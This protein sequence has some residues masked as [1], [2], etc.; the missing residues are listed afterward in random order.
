MDRFIAMR[1]LFGHFLL[2]VSGS[3][4]SQNWEWAA[5]AGGFASDKSTDMGI[6]PA[7]NVYVCGY[8]NGQANFGTISS[9]SGFGKQGFLARIDSQG[10]WQWMREADGGWDERVLGMCVDSVNGFIYVTGC[11]WTWGPG[12]QLS[13]GSYTSFNNPGDADEIFVGKFDYSGNCLWLIGAGGASDDHG[14]DLATDQSGNIYLTGFVS[15]EYYPNPEVA[16]FGSLSSTPMNMGDS[17]GFVAKI[18]PA[19]VFQWVRTFEAV[20]GERDNRIAVDLAGNS[21]ITGGFWGNK[22]F[23]S[24]TVASN[25]GTDIFVV[26]Y[27]ASGTMQWLRTVGSTYDERGNGITI[28]PYGDIYVTGEFR[29]RLVFGTDSLNNNGGPGGRDIFVAKI[30]AA[31]NWIWAKKAGSDKGGERGNRIISNKTGD[32][33]VTGQFKDSARFG[34]TITLSGDPDSIQVF[35]ACIDTGGKWRWALEA[36][37]PVEDRGNGIAADDSCHLYVCG[38]YQQTAVFDSAISLNAQSRKDVFVAKIGEACWSQILPP[39]PPPPP[40]LPECTLVV[41]NVFTPNEDG[42]N[43]AFRLDTA[44][45]LEL[46]LDIYNRWGNKMTHLSGP[47][48]K[49]DGTFDGKQASE[50]VY[51]YAGSATLAN[52]DVVALKGFVTLIR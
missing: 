17:L 13:F 12:S 7:G 8:F 15:N 10:V 22:Q 3:L 21:Y 49:W 2:L 32:L 46:S 33:F 9:G 27:D 44:C 1:V 51:Y 19:G 39:P 30:T 34:S 23:G 31:G 52:G 35:V 6:D 28:D 18:S 47:D 48:Q 42:R 25:G 26:K 41:P 11:Y 37:G 40:L 29:D 16:T 38:Y 14:Y 45:V 24:Q 43:D 4:F 5:S 36:G 50:G 20:D